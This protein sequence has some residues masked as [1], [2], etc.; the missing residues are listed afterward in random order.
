MEKMEDVD[1]ILVEG[2][3]RTQKEMISTTSQL[4][5]EIFKLVGIV[6]GNKK[7]EL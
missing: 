7:E 3:L 4:Q 6:T 2:I 5:D 1:H